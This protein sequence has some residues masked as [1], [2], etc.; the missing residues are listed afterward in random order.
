MYK[1]PENKYATLIATRPMQFC[2]RLLM[3]DHLCTALVAASSDPGAGKAFHE[4]SGRIWALCKRNATSRN[5]IVYY[6]NTNIEGKLIGNRDEI[7]SQH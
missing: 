2:W 4:F 5:A 3:S 6:R 1:I 7:T